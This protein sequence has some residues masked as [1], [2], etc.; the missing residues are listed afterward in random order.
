VSDPCRGF[1]ELP[2]AVFDDLKKMGEAIVEE[3]VKK[4][5]PKTGGAASLANLAPMFK[6]AYS[7]PDW[8]RLIDQIAMGRLKYY[9]FEHAE[10]L[11][12]EDRD[13]Y[14]V[15]LRHQCG[16]WWIGYIDHQSLRSATRQSVER[17]CDAL[18]LAGCYCVRA[19]QRPSESA[20][21]AAMMAARTKGCWPS[22]IIMSS[23]FEH[24]LRFEVEAST[25]LA[26]GRFMGVPM[27]VTY[28]VDTFELEFVP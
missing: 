14:R 21:H 1:V 18:D 24:A 22:R 3:A 5:Q 17:V 28:G 26:G 20:L 12:D 19:D 10:T 15:R 25:S 27:A 2:K 8:P 11:I 6:R 9:G 7:S 4:A 16:S 23:R 13:G